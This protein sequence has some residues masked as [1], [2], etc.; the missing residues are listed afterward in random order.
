MLRVIVFEAEVYEQVEAPRIRRRVGLFYVD[1][2]S[3]Y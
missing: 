3:C 1:A 2:Q